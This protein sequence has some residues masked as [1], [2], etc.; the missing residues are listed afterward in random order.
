LRRLY[1]ITTRAVAGLKGIKGNKLRNDLVLNHLGLLEDSRA[2]K[3]STIG[4][5]LQNMSVIQLNLLKS[6][7]TTFGGGKEKTSEIDELVTISFKI[8]EVV[9]NQSN[10]GTFEHWSGVL[11]EITKTCQ[12]NPTLKELAPFIEQFQSLLIGRRRQDFMQKFIKDANDNE[13]SSLDEEICNQMEIISNFLGESVIEKNNVCLSGLLYLLF[14]VTE[15]PDDSISMKN[16]L[17]NFISC[18]KLSG[19]V[20]KKTK[21]LDFF[22]STTSNIESAFIKRWIQ[23]EAA[24]D[25]QK[26]AKM[27][28]AVKRVSDSTVTNRFFDLVDDIL[29]QE[30]KKYRQLLDKERRAVSLK[31]E[32]P[33]R[34]AHVLKR[35]VL[36]MVFHNLASIYFPQLDPQESTTIMA[37]NNP[38]LVVPYSIEINSDHDWKQLLN[39]KNSFKRANF[40]AKENKIEFEWILWLK[41]VVIPSLSTFVIPVETVREILIVIEEFS[42]QELLET[43]LM[44]RPNRWLDHSAVLS[45]MRIANELYGRDL[46]DGPSTST[47]LLSVLRRCQSG[48]TI[49]NMFR[50]KL[51]IEAKATQKTRL[52]PETFKKI[53]WSLAQLTGD[54]DRIDRLNASSLSQWPK[55]IRQMVNERL[56]SMNTSLQ[57]SRLDARIGVDK[58]DTFISHCSAILD[59]EN[60]SD[61]LQIILKNIFKYSWLLEDIAMLKNNPSNDFLEMIQDEE[62]IKKFMKSKSKR[63]L[64]LEDI[65]KELEMF[66]GESKTICTLMTS[67]NKT[68]IQ[69]AEEIKKRRI[70]FE[71][72]DTSDIQKWAIKAKENSDW[73]V[74]EFLSIACQSIKDWKGFYPRDTQLVAVLLFNGSSE[75]G[76]SSMAQISTGEGKTIITALLAIYLSLRKKFVHVVTSSSVLAEENVVEVKDLCKRFCVS[77]DNICDQQCSSDEN[78]RRNR[79]KNDII[80]GDL[81]SFQRDLLVTKVY[82]ETY[83]DE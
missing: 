22:F 43:T 48:R 25:N 23:C 64:N 7:Q 4:E 26:V 39:L 36:N 60:K 20:F 34:Y 52:D 21:I 27:Y 30:E 68:I 56:W 47:Y 78:E 40:F 11:L 80:Y 13:N 66:S 53:I 19:L 31:S 10:D 8:Y 18:I 71:N 59:E 70:D 41:D 38:S 74:V 55:V 75:K 37:D 9:M 57:I 46:D 1:D 62:S 32:S 73:D 72:Y 28:D 17:K 58:T 6:R 79:Y 24:G 45:V 15:R 77:V 16:I 51:N 33:L 29:T 83:F 67:T 5:I 54:I 14:T 50:R 69:Q 63:A 2:S 49:M 12:N 44:S 61:R 65:Q 81:S 82:I 35:E 3:L 42:F 76:T